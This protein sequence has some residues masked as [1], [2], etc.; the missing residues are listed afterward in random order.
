MSAKK[1]LYIFTQ[2]PY[3]NSAGIEGL[4]A[5]LIGAAF[6]Q[7]VSVLFINNGVFQI[8][9]KQ[10]PKALVKQF[11]KTFKALN[12]VGVEHIYVDELSMAARGLSCSELICDVQSLETEQ[13]K[14]LI[15][16]Q[17]RVFTF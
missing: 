4:D 13:V 16:Q 17:F 15:A 14:E 7:E 6:D 10:A 8:K 1:I 3:S 11:T 2:A 5:T 12:D 9:D